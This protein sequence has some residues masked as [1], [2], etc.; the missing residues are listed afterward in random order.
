LQVKINDGLNLLLLHR[1]LPQVAV[2]WL[3]EGLCS[4]SASVQVD[5]L[6]LLNRHLRQAAKRCASCQ[7]NDNVN[8][9]Q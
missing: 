4:Y 1:C 3:I 7:E 9:K 8:N 5:S 2:T 6:V